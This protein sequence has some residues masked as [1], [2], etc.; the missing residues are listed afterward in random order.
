MQS[1]LRVQPIEKR[2][3]LTVLR[4]RLLV[5]SAAG[6]IAGCPLAASMHNT[7]LGLVLGTL[8]GSAYGLVTLATATRSIE[9]LFT[10]AALGF[11][12]WTVLNTILIPVVSG[13]GPQWS[14]ENMRILL[15]ALVGWIV[16]GAMLGVLIPGLSAALAAFAGPPPLAV[17]QPAELQPIRIVILG[18]GFAGMATAEELERQFGANVGVD[19]TLISEGNALLFTP[20]LAEVAGS[21]LEPSHISSPLR[22]SLHRTKVLRARVAGVDFERKCMLADSGDGA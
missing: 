16:S 21:S 8:V 19:F 6:L 12:L 13:H 4:R 11:P 9:S 17:A 1:E 14:A 18:G 15:P 7:A 10:A 20:M 22:T 2:I 5:G 3:L